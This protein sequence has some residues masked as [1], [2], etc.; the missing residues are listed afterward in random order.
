MAK[1]DQKK[2]DIEQTQSEGRKN[3]LVEIYKIHVQYLSNENTLQTTINRFY[4]TVMSGLFAFLFAFLQRKDDI[5]PD[6]SEKERIVGYS[7]T[8][9]G[10]L[11]MLLSTIWWFTSMH[12][13]RRISRKWR[14]LL[15]L[16]KELDFQFFSQDSALR[17]KSISNVL[18]SPFYMFEFFMPFAFAIV[19]AALFYIGMSNILTGEFPLPFVTP[20]ETENIQ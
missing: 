10:Y 3:R 4:P 1:K 15:E 7:I 19:F 8:V 2:L 5:F 14:V 6:V 9:V 13:Q 20:Q 16:E 18:Y 11:G 17:G 12:F